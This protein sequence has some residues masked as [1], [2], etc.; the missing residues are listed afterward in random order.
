MPTGGDI[1]PFYKQAQGVEGL[2]AVANTWNGVT[3]AVANRYKSQYQYDAN[4]N[5]QSAKRWDNAGTQYDDLKYSC[6]KSG[7]QLL[8]NRLYHLNESINGGYGDIGIDASAY[9]NAHED[10]N[11]LNNYKYDKLG[12][13]IADKREEIANIEWTVSGKV[14]HITRTAG[15]TKP[16]LWFTYGADGQRTSKTVGDPL[17]GGFRE[18]YLRDAQG[19]VMAM[20]K[21]ADNGTSLKVTERPI[22]GSKRIG[23]YVRQMELMGEP[24]V[25]QWPYT[26]P[27]QAP[28]KRYE[29]TD[30]LGNVNTVVTGR[31][32]PLLGPGVQ[33]QAEV[34]SATG[35]EPFGSLLPGRNY[36]S[37]N[38][39]FGFN[40]QEKDDE[41]HG[42][43]GTSYDFGERMQDP[44]VGRWLSLDPKAVDLASWSPYH[45][46]LNNPII[47]IDPDG[48]FPYTFHVRSFAPPNAFKGSGFHDD[49]RGFSTSTNVTSR[50]KQNFTIDPTARTYSGGKPTSDPTY[51]NG[52]NMGTATD[53]GG[54][55]N[56]EFSTNSVGSAMA[57]VSAAFE[58][59]NPAFHGTAPDIEVSTAISITENLKKGQVIISLDLS[60]KQFPATESFVQDAAGN[61]VFLAGAAAYGTAGDLVD[62]DKAKVASVDLVVGINEKGIFQNVTMGGKTYSIEEFNKLGTS[63]PAGPKPREEAPGK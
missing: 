57:S 13:L 14:K 4:G 41:I 8:R 51:W 6:E 49:G 32:L 26:Q 23:T 28:L 1:R 27:M 54:I 58:G 19:N 9:H 31:L 25:H 35:Y 53:R 38:Y 7:T 63:Q 44:R 55:S 62:A 46:G 20:Y 52:I 42:A 59:S 2:A 17:N 43:T 22:Y 29:L 37:A 48:Q 61:A 11:L 12:N 33:Y 45:F 60:S 39:R 15:S 10:V 16:E 24:A 40:S 30:H 47:F 34:V 18:W 56:P 3:D 21:Y 5:I 50:I 36:S